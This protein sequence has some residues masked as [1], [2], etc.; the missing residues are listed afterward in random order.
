MTVTLKPHD[1]APAAALNT[2]AEVGPL[3]SV[4][5]SVAAPLAAV[6]F[7]P[8]QAPSVAHAYAA[9]PAGAERVTLAGA[10]TVADGEGVT[11]G[12]PGAVGLDTCGGAR[13]C[14]PS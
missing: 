9:K 1:T 7:T 10:V 6:K 5:A 2:D 13:S 14:G 12:V 8:A 3:V 11:V 4:S